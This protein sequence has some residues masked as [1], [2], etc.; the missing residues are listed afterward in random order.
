VNVASPFPGVSTLS[1]TADDQLVYP[2]TIAQ[3]LMAAANRQQQLVF[4]GIVLGV[5][6][7]TWIG[8][9]TI[10]FAPSFTFWQ[11]LRFR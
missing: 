3:D 4:G 6:L 11:M 5:L 10:V 8:I 1:W 9:L 7:S 2:I